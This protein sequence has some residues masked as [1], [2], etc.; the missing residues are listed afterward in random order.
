MKIVRQLASWLLEHDRI[1]PDDYQ[2]VLLAIMGGVSDQDKTVLRR[3]R[4]RKKEQDAAE[5]DT[6]VWWNLRGAGER[7]HGKAGRKRGQKATADLTPVK[8]WDLELRLPDML[9]PASASLDVFPLAVLLLAVDEARGNRRLPDW[10]GF[11]ATATELYKVGAEELHDAFLAAMKGHGCELGPI[12]AAAEMGS[13]LFPKG[14]L[15]HLSGDSV[16]ALRKRID[17]EETAFS[18]NKEDW[19][20]RYPAFNV[21]NEACLVRNR[22]RR[23][24]RLWVQSLTEWD[25]H[26]VATGGAPGICLVFGKTFV[27]VPNIVW[28][29]LQNPAEPRLGSVRGL[30]VLPDCHDTAP[31][32][33][34][35]VDGVPTVLFNSDCIDPPD[36]PCGFCRVHGEGLRE[37]PSPVQIVGPVVQSGG[38]TPELSLPAAPRTLCWGPEEWAEAVANRRRISK[39]VLAEIACPWRVLHAYLP[40]ERWVDLLLKRWHLMRNIVQWNEIDTVSIGTA[41]WVELLSAHPRLAAY[42][43]WNLFTAADLDRILFDCFRFGVDL[44]VINPKELA[45]YLFTRYA[46]YPHHADVYLR[47]LTNGETWNCILSG[48]YEW[49]EYCPWRSLPGRDWTTILIHWPDLADR[50]D[51]GKLTGWQWTRLLLF[52]PQFAEFCD[53]GRLDDYDWE[54]LLSAQPQFADRCDWSKLNESSRTCILRRQPQLAAV[55]P[56]ATS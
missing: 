12:L 46:K 15:S 35:L 6:E 50:C 22:L 49:V 53:W 23:V 14:F 8:V 20:L 1:T 7:A 52:Q 41:K 16:T 32:L 34:I 30:M 29:K 39:G 10:A 4:A 25:A 37:L 28:W 11:A 47:K 5:D 48:H 13:T 18:A 26:G 21:F 31:F 17:G 42:A 55:I 45:N 33:N 3:A 51:W 38:R 19:I 44:N 56:N 40:G 24:Y 9:L 36:P 2:D 54:K 43:P 27:H